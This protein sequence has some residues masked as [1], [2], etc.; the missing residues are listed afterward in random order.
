MQAQLDGPLAGESV[1]FLAISMGDED[2]YLEAFREEMGTTFPWLLLDRRLPNP[3][4]QAA[5]DAYALEEEWSHMLLLDADGIIRAR[6]YGGGTSGKD[7]DDASI[8]EQ[9][10]DILAQAGGS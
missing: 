4:F 1:L 2:F 5:Y 6:D 10:P 8:Y 7:L 3:A 9:I